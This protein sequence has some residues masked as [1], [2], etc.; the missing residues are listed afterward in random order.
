MHFNKW[1]AKLKWPK[2]SISFSEIYNKYKYNE[3]FKSASFFFLVVWYVS[4]FFALLRDRFYMFISQTLIRWGHVPV[5]V[6]KPNFWPKFR[7]KYGE[8]K[9]NYH[10]KNAFEK[11]FAHINPSRDIEVK[12]IHYDNDFDNHID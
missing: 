12:E 1:I 6:N 3:S 11:G 10:A 9:H 7:E 8:G 5:K 4:E 2:T